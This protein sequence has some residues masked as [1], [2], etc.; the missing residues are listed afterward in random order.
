MTES[1]AFH[2]NGRAT[3]RELHEVIG[4]FRKEMREEFRALKA[5][6]DRHEQ[7]ID[8]LEA[9]PAAVFIAIASSAISGLIGLVIGR[10]A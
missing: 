5:S 2:G 4:E 3:V 10:V 1:E 9:R 7:R 6:W 8:A